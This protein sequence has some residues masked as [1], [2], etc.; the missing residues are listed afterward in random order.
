[1]ADA[2]ING[3]FTGGPYPL[4]FSPVPTLV[5][6]WSAKLAGVELYRRRGLSD[7]D[8]T[9]DKL[10]DLEKQVNSD[11]SWYVSGSRRLQTEL[12]H[13]SATAPVVVGVNG[14]LVPDSF[15]RV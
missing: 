11:M 7:T 15:R 2:Q 12:S 13:S 8:E 14:R 1:M 4:D 6:D 3:L 5:E 9:G 10:T